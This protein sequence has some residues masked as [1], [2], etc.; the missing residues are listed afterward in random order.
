MKTFTVSDLHYVSEPGSTNSLLREIWKKEPLL[1]EAYAL[2]SFNQTAGRG[3]QNNVWASE[4]DKNIAYSVFLRPGHLSPAFSFVLSQAVSLALLETLSGET[5]LQ[6]EIKWPNDIYVENK[7]IAGIL[8]ENELRGKSILGSIVGIGINV[9]QEQFSPNLPNPVSAF[10][11]C[12]RTFDLT[13]LTLALH[14]RLGEA[15]ARTFTEEGKAEIAAD[16]H[17]HLYRREDFHSY[18]E[19]KRLFKARVLRVMPGGQLELE[20]DEGW[21]RAFAFKEIEY[22]I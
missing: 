20:S 12:G 8:I 9:N 5:G 2:A 16:Y 17:R 11:L 7:K 18:R 6:A 4:A 3:Q 22:L 10:Q 14:K 19:G 1:S 21:I 15:Y 13:D